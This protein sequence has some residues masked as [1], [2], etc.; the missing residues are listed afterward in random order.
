VLRRVGAEREGVAGTR[1]ERRPGALQLHD[2]CTIEFAMAPTCARNVHPVQPTVRKHKGC[3]T[4]E[5]PGMT[6]SR[7]SMRSSVASLCRDFT[8]G[9]RRHSKAKTSAPSA[10]RGC[11]RW[12]PSTGARGTTGRLRR[13]GRDRD[14]QAP[15]RRRC[16]V[17][18]DVA[19]DCDSRTP[20]W[21][22]SDHVVDDRRL[23][24][25]FDRAVTAF[26]PS[27]YCGKTSAKRN[28]SCEKIPGERIQQCRNFA[29]TGSSTWFQAGTRRRCRPRIL[30]RAL[31]HHRN[32]DREQ[33]W[34]C[35]SRGANPGR[36]PALPRSGITPSW[37]G[38]GQLKPALVLHHRHRQRGNGNPWTAT[39]SAITFRTRSRRGCATRCGGRLRESH[40]PSRAA[41]IREANILDVAHREQATKPH[42]RDESGAPR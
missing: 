23:P 29:S 1:D 42:A 9:R 19:C 41:E 2:L 24:G 13:A 4:W 7:P 30:R 11:A 35:H 26:I 33:A 6:E 38:A 8:R 18:A 16:D 21:S 17:E 12:R 39:S 14:G 15:V 28:R 37:R 3:R 32:R 40:A 20:T 5:V 34:V 25:A 10:E 22:P 31:V 27:S 36:D